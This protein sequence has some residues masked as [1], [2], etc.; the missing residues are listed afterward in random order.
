MIKLRNMTHWI[1]I[2][3]LV[4]ALF[5]SMPRLFYLPQIRYNRLVINRLEKDDTYHIKRHQQLIDQMKPEAIK[6][7][8]V[9][10]FTLG[11]LNYSIRLTRKK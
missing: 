4:P 7:G 10:I 2:I 5:Y 3:V 1:G 9:F 8:I 11:F 6:G